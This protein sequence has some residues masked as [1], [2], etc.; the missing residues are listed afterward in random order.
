M[1]VQSQHLDSSDD[2]S[3]ALHSVE[4]LALKGHVLE[5]IGEL[6]RI[7]RSHPDHIQ[8]L[9][10]RTRISV[11]SIVRDVDQNIRSLLHKLP[12]LVSKD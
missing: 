1:R 10:G 12:Y 9:P 8:M 11:P 5:A 2:P 4:D 3:G 6:T 7:N